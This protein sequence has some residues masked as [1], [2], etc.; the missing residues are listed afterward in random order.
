MEFWSFRRKLENMGN[1]ITANNIFLI[2]VNPFP[3][4]NGI[5]Q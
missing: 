2:H 4:T 3:K 5:I 1:Y